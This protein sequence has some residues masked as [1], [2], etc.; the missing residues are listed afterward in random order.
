ML[1]ES[2]ADTLGSLV[3][4]TTKTFSP[5]GRAN[6]DGCPILIAGAAAGCGALLLSTWANK[7]NGSRAKMIIDN[8][9]MIIDC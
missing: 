2:V 3:F 8:F 7:L 5:L 9:F 4:C 6:V 1:K